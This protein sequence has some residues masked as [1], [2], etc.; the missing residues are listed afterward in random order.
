MKKVVQKITDISDSNAVVF[1][2]KKADI[3]ELEKLKIS[4]TILKKIKQDTANTKKEDIFSEFYIADKRFEKLFVFI[5][6]SKSKR[7]IVNFIGKHTSKISEKFTLFCQKDDNLKDIIDT[8]ILSRYTYEKYK[9]EQKK[10]SIYILASSKNTQNIEDILVTIENVVLARDL[11]EMPSNDLTPETFAT[12][13]KKTNFKRTKVKVLWPKAI[14][15]NKLGLLYAVGNGSKNKPHMVIL[16]RIVD[17][18]APTFWI[19][20]KGITFD[21]GGIQVKPENHMY[22]MKG[23]MWWA[24]VTYALMKELDRKDIKV[25]IVACLC[26]AENSISSTSY[27]PSDILT[28]YTGKTVEIIH[29][30]AEGRL[31]LADGISYISKNYKTTNILS[32]ATLTGAVMVALGFRYAGIMGTDRHMLDTILS[33]SK[34]STEQYIEL[35]FDEHFLE[36]TKSKIADYKNLDRGVYA[37][38]SM[39]GAF[40]HNF[41][42]NNEDYTHID[43]AG[44]YLNGGDPYGKVNKW[45]TGFWVESLSEVFQSL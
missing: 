19:V 21:T 4:E 11:W 27:K 15:K 41:L 35:P 24:A 7:K 43:I 1:I 14:E 36:K 25:N 30:D 12:I 10:D 2:T 20:G 39:G 13:V 9:K 44:A 22:E 17:K 5:I 26:L 6:E 42:E 37:G 8:C 34:E 32:I 23:D 28:G 3:K 31:V 45:A 33:Y 29:T 18:K 16:E 40:L 38:S